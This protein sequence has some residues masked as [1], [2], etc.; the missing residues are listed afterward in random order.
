MNYKVEIHK[1]MLLQEFG[2][3][4][5]TA[6]AAA[7]TAEIPE[8][9]VQQLRRLWIQRH[10]HNDPGQTNPAGCAE[11]TGSETSEAWLFR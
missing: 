7:A 4:E 8:A 5:S 11:K 2:S 3:C 10:N 9:D 6:A 1:N